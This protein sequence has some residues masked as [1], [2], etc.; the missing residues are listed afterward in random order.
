[1]TEWWTYRP[2]D[3]LMFSPRIYWRLFEHINLAT[4]PLAA[5]AVVLG[6][7]LLAWCWRRPGSD[8][9]AR[10][11]ALLLAAAW[12]HVAWAF[13]WQRFTPIQWAA[14]GFAL[15]FAVQ[16]AALLAAAWPVTG[17]AASSLRR[18]AGLALAVWALLLHPL[19]AW[20]QGRPWQQAE[21]F[22]LAPDPTVLATL[23][24]L[25]MAPARQQAANW[26]LAALWVLPVSWCGLSA[27]TLFAMGSM[28][29]A[30]PLAGAGLALV[31]AL[32][33][34]YWGRR[35]RNRCSAPISK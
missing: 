4:W 29:A 22:G 14:T 18:H 11:T 3:F 8:R 6:L 9:A 13:L 15:A 23:A 12:G 7:G 1:V 10:L 17:R 2:S 20:A 33:A 26:W 32:T 21:V 30:I 34:F 19:L 24:W 16:A 25:L 28:Q 31:V 35:M 5:L 27:A